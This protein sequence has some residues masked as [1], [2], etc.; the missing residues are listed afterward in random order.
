M[1][2][3]NAARLSAKAR[4]FSESVIREMRRTRWR[5]AR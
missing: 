4:Q 3:T 1:T 5:T 2:L